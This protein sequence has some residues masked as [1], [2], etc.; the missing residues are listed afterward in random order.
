MDVL[1]NFPGT[2]LA[3]LYKIKWTDFWGQIELAYLQNG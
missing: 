2:L 1:K 3:I